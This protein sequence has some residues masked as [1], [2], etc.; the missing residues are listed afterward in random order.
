[1]KHN[2]DL[3]KGLGSGE[4]SLDLG[5]PKG[6]GVGSKIKSRDKVATKCGDLKP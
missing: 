5:F 1:M 6:S 3:K 2:G 4:K